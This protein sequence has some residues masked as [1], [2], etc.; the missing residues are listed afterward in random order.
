MVLIIVLLQS[1]HLGQHLGLP[2]C[3]IGLKFTN[4]YHPKACPVHLYIVNVIVIAPAPGHPLLV[5]V[6][7]EA[8]TSPSDHLMLSVSLDC[9]YPCDFRNS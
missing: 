9:L 8:S 2:S 7:T 4:G 6:L 5:L 1:V 3:A